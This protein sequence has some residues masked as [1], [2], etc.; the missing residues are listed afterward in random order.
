MKKYLGLVA[1]VAAM[2]ASTSVAADVTLTPPAG[3]SRCSYQACLPVAPTANLCVTTEAAPWG[4]AITRLLVQPGR[5]GHKVRLGQQGQ[6]GRK[7]KLGHR[8]Q[9]GQQGHRDYK[10]I[11]G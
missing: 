4:N 6:R 11:L 2:Y 5:K 7:V 1:L 9:K 3:G 10:V 8:G